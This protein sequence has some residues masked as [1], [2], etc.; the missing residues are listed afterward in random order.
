MKKSLLTES[1]IARFK[2]LAGIPLKEG[3]GYG[4]EE[5]EMKMSEAAPQLPPAGEMPAEE[6]MAPEEGGEEMSME[7]PPAEENPVEGD[8]SAQAAEIVSSMLQDLAA[9]LQK[10]GISIDVS[11]DSEGGMEDAEAEYYIKHSSFA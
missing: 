9:K 11:S 3:Y 8:Q 2:K 10:I 4:H 7:E 1:E 6:P 5:E